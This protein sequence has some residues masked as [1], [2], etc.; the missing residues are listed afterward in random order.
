MLKRS[1]KSGF[2][3]QEFVATTIIGAPITLFLP[4]AMLTKNNKMKP[5]KLRQIEQGANR[6]VLYNFEGVVNCD[7]V[8]PAPIAAVL[9]TLS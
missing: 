4:E 5:R 2:I 6:L 3:L 7:S 1:I 9:E 8:T